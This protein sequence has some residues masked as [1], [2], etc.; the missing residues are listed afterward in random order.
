MQQLLRVSISK[1]A[2]LETDLTEDLPAIECDPSQLR[3][4]LMNLVINASE[5][6]DDKTGSILIRTGVEQVHGAPLPEASFATDLTPG[7]YVF[8]EVSDNGCGMDRDTLSKIFDPFF[9]TKFVG[10]GL[11]LAA[12]SG[13]VRAHRGALRITSEPGRG[14]L[15]RILLRACSAPADPLP[16]SP[17]TPA[18]WRGSGT[19]LVADDE[20]A[21][22]H[23]TGHMLKGLGF[24]VLPAADGEGAIAAFRNHLDKIVAIVLDLTMPHLSGEDTLREIRRLRPDV[25][26]LLVSGFSEQEAMTRF[27]GQQASDFLAKPFKV[28]ELREKMQ[29][30]LMM[31]D[32]QTGDTGTADTLSRQER[33]DSLRAASGI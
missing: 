14:S 13:I 5:A 7:D 27:C 31:A 11:G 28:E 33:H 30:I 9:T 22:R 20:P 19:V 10:R 4:V 2:A 15:F 29:A 17:I 8:L 12:V 23:V 32:S 25:P 26:V 6:L 1:K 16:A 18:M 21:V 24:D 3:Q